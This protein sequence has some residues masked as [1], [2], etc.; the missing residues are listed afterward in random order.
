MYGHSP[1]TYYISI[2]AMQRHD[3]IGKHQTRN[4]LYDKTKEKRQ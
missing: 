2:G 1:S 4:A 3:P